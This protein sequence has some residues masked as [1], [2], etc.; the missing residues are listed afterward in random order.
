MS[1]ARQAQDKQNRFRILKTTVYSVFRIDFKCGIE[2]FLTPNC[3]SLLL[4]S[5]PFLIILQNILKVNYL[6]G[7]PS[8]PGLL[9]FLDKPRGNAE[10]RP[11]TDHAGGCE[12]WLSS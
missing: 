12:R 4:S 1:Y 11:S 3:L 2:T 5:Y 8:H 7:S 6:Y 10:L 9:K